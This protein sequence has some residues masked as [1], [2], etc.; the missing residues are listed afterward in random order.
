MTQTT[1]QRPDREVC[2][3][4]ADL[5]NVAECGAA[6]H[7]VYWVDEDGVTCDVATRVCTGC[8]RAGRPDGPGYR[9]AT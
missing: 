3:H 6:E 8:L 9:A 4:C 1:H 2:T 5:L 7:N